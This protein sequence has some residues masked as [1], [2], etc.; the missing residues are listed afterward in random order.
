MFRYLFVIALILA[1]SEVL[2]ATVYTYTSTANYSSKTDYA[3]CGVGQNCQNFTLSMSVSGSF[4][5]LSAIPANTTGYDVI[6]NFSNLSSYSFSDGITT[7]NETNSVLYQFSVDTDSSG[8]IQTAN[9][10]LEHFQSNPLWFDY[11]SLGSIS[12][13]GLSCV[14]TGTNAA[15]QTICTGASFNNGISTASG[16]TG[17]WSVTTPTTQAV[18][19]LSEWTQMLLGLMVI[20]MLGWHFHKQRSN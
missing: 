14:V 20:S 10:L 18:P 6:Q 9:I 2:S 15:N 7:Y 8:N 11:V 19:T 17:S 4:T 5:L 16:A 13:H 1:S 12:Y 3:S